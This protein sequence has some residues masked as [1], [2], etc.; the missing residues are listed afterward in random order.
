[1]NNK[2]KLAFSI[3]LLLLCVVLCL[4][5]I[6]NV[7]DN[8]KIIK[9]V[10]A[11][12]VSAA[13]MFFSLVPC[14]FTQISISSSQID[15]NRYNFNKHNFVDRKI[16]YKDMIKQIGSLDSTSENIMWIKLYGE[17]GIGKKTLVSKLFQNYKY[18]FNRFYFIYDEEKRKISE[19]LNKKY[20]LKNTADYNDIL[21]LRTMAKSHRTFVIVESTSAD[22]NKRATNL[23]V[24][25]NKNNVCRKKLI[26]ISFD[27]GSVQSEA[28]HQTFVYEYKLGRLITDDSKLMATKLLKHNCTSIDNIVQASDGNPAAIK[29]LCNYYLKAKDKFENSNWI[30]NILKLKDDSKEAFLNFCILSVVRGSFTKCVADEITDLSRIE[31]LMSADLLA[32]S[33]TDDYY[34]PEWLLRTILISNEYNDQIELGIEA[35]AQKSILTDNEKQKITALVKKESNTILKVLKYYSNNRMFVEIKDFNS[36]LNISFNITDPLHKQIMAIIMDALLELGEYGI[37]DTYFHNIRIPIT[38]ELS[39]I[40]FKIHLL[41]ANYYHLTSQYDESNQIYIMLQNTKLANAYLLEINFNIAHNWRHMGKLDLARKLFDQIENAANHNSKFY[42]RSVTG[43]ISIDYFMENSFQPNLSVSILRSL[44]SKQETD[45]NVYR[46]IANIYRRSGNESENTKAITLLKE[47]ICELEQTPL[48][49][50]YDYY[51]DLA[52]CYR[53]LCGKKIFYFNDAIINYNLALIFAESNHDINLKLCAQFGKAL[54]VY[55]KDKNKN[56]LSKSLNLLLDEAKIS[57]VIYYGILTSIDILENDDSIR[58][59]LEE[60]KFSHY[61]KVLDSKDVNLLQITVM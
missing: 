14:V 24:E 29:T 35:L 44:L 16:I 23:L 36:K 22:F 38:N 61:I 47:K 57:D 40:D 25:W 27:N 31:Y 7:D 1:M 59:K 17:D 5:D 12:I 19:L 53:Q 41:I 8:F 37:F 50:I 18:P 51:F 58:S 42:I 13:D 56:R 55:K 54:V 46:H 6:I 52:E 39:D 43:R 30:E 28:K 3:C 15:P 32:K 11:A 2:A 10:I 9:F 21:Y 33:Q 45:Y 48:R 34:V 60:M 26:L 20:P 4:F 49:I